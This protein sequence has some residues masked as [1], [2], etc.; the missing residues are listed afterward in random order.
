VNDPAGLQAAAWLGAHALVLYAA[1]SFLLLAATMLGWHLLQGTAL[2]RPRCSRGW[3]TPSH[4][5][6]LGPWSAQRCCC[7]GVLA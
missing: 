6:C 4:S 7:G 3:G 2:Q 5:P 1:I